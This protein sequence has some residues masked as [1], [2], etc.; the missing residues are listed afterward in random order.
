MGVT[1]IHKFYGDG[2]YKSV[3][4]Y[5]TLSFHVTVRH[6]FRCQAVHHILDTYIS[7]IT[8]K[9]NQRLNHVFQIHSNN[10]I[11]AQLLKIGTNN[12]NKIPQLLLDT[13]QKISLA[14]RNNWSS[15]IS[16]THSGVI[17]D[18]KL[19]NKNKII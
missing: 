17:F 9:I 11:V 10:F 5:L 13:S 18:Y 15:D 16:I 3:V 2:D 14:V 7:S 1:Y 12:N 4:L 6:I 19:Y 8:E